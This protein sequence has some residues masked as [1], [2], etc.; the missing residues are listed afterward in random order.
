MLKK[1]MYNLGVL[2]KTVTECVCVC[3]YMCECVC[4]GVRL[5]L[6]F[7]CPLKSSCRAGDGGATPTFWKHPD[8]SHQHTLMFT[9]QRSCSRSSTHQAAVPCS[10]KINTHH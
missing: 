1:K 7:K 9:N 5:L 8:Y 4:V 3:V 10:Q 6:S 2:P